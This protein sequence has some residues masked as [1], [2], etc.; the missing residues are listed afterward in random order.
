MDAD[1]AP[2]P[3]ALLLDASCPL[4]CV[5]EAVEGRGRGGPDAVPVGP[6]LTRHWESCSGDGQIAPSPASL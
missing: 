6:R 4:S 2:A 1:A 5:T 3:L